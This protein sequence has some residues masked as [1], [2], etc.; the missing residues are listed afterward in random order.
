M[1][2]GQSVLLGAYVLGA[3]SPAE[4]ESVERHLNECETCRAEIVGLAPLPGLLSRVSVDDIAEQPV[5]DPP[6]AEL[7][8]RPRHRSPMMRRRWVLAIM[9]VCLL[10]LVVAVG[11]LILPGSRH[12]ETSAA[13]AV[14][15]G[16]D[17]T[18]GVSGTATVTAR[19]WGTGVSLRL[20]YVQL[21][22]HCRLVVNARN[23][24]SEVAGSW[25]ATSRLDD[26]DIPGASS[27]QL[28]QIASMDVY[29]STGK[30][31]VHLTPNGSGPGATRTGG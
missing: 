20:R 1:S 13:T 29:T 4:R 25:V 14:L 10:M 12:P 24:T 18:S 11:G 31:L 9:G 7:P 30:R 21:S 28:N 22:A 3:V 17:A 6:P 16:S 8:P 27:V 19:R 2:C 26:T 23:G 15:T 5:A